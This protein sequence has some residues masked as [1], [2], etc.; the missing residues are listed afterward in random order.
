MKKIRLI[1][2]TTSLFIASGSLLLA[3]T[4]EKKS[5]ERVYQFTD[6][7]VVPH[8]PVDNQAS[9]STCWSFASIG[10]IEAEILRL[11][12]KEYN[13]SEMFIVRH[14][15]R[16]KIEKYVRMHGAT[17]LSPG[18]GFAEVP[19]VIKQYGLIPEADYSGM[20][21]GEDRHIH[22]E[23][24]NVMKAYGDAI[25]K[26]GNRKLSPV[27]K[28]GID[29]LLDTYLGKV[30][31]EF[32]VDGKKY[33]SKSFAE[34]TKINPDDYLQIGSFLHRE[35]YKPFIMEIPD[36]WNW[37]STYNVTLDE[38]METLDYAIENGYTVHWAADVSDKGFAWRSGFAVVPEENIEAMSA[39]DRDRWAGVSE[40]DRKKQ[41]YKFEEIVPEK[42]IT[43][44]LRQQAFDNYE[45]TDDHGMLIVG[46]AK[47]Q[48]GTI[49]YKVKNSWGIGDHLYEG[50][51]YA[52]KSYIAYRTLFFSLHKDAVPNKIMKKI[53][54]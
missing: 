10:L 33:T 18:G 23:M 19:N 32:T 31:T 6:L 42:E 53:N 39:T 16:E 24:D 12:G 7:V 1:F 2:L 17:N 40:A 21:I 50:Y 28:D 38:M 30:P 4:E 5:D 51:F 35:L 43:P 41:L 8:T 9:S 20:V 11:T 22:G 36:N 25:L 48:N 26:N 37:S 27:W 47:D 54:F 14:S 3:Q 46:K 49:Y 29:A 13:L 52:S 44:E 34:S 15:W 45:T